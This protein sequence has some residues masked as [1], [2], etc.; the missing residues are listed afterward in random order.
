MLTLI[1]DLP[2]RAVAEVLC[3]AIQ[4]ML[5]HSQHND[6]VMKHLE[7]EY[8]LLCDLCQGSISVS[9]FVCTSCHYEICLLCMEKPPIVEVK[10]CRYPVARSLLGEHK[11]VPVTR[12]TPQQL[13]QLLQEIHAAIERPIVSTSKPTSDAQTA[14]LLK[15]AHDFRAVPV[16]CPD[17]IR[18]FEDLWAAQV[19]LL[20]E[21][22]PDFR[23]EIWTPSVFMRGHEDEMV[24]MITHKGESLA[25]EQVTL[26]SFLRKFEESVAETGFIVKLKDY[27]PSQSFSSAYQDHHFAFQSSLPFPMYTSERGFFNL[28][29]H[30]PA[31]VN[32]G[33]DVR[34]WSTA[35][36]KPDL[37][38]KLYMATGDND[39]RMSSDED[40]LISSLKTTKTPLPIGKAGFGSH[41]SIQDDLEDIPE[42]CT[43]DFP[44]RKGSTRLHLDMS[45]AVNIMVEDLTGVGALWTIFAAEDT[46]RV[47]AF[48]REQHHL[49]PSSPCPIHAQRYYLRGSDLRQLFVGQ[50]VIPYIFTQRKGQAVFIPAGCAHQ[51][52][53]L[54]PYVT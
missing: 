9:S 10:T 18:V 26:K 50:G 13:R 48:L 49:S 29:A 34:R 4:K 19:P 31:Y 33:N 35:S 28:A 24:R 54:S 43:T 16:L 6:A 37:G 39:S 36:I 52:S 11:W 44:P 22:L 8:R 23:P 53:T 3:P 40:L 15:G 2:Q 7:T 14:I 38:P 5:A 27:P 47:R 1:D 41:P 51:V 46:D 17:D 32:F 21:P 42:A 20:V 25:E 45:G 30:I 12:R